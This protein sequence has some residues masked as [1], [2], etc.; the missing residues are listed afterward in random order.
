MLKQERA[1]QIM[2]AG[3]AEDMHWPDWR[4][5]I[6]VLWQIVDKTIMEADTDR[7]GKISFEEFTKM[8]E[9]TDVSLSMTLGTNLCLHHSSPCSTK[10]NHWRC[11]RSVLVESPESDSWNESN[12]SGL[13]Y[14]ARL[15]DQTSKAVRFG[16]ME[17]LLDLVEQMKIRMLELRRA[18]WHGPSHDQ[19][20]WYVRGY[21]GTRV[22]CAWLPSCSDDHFSSTR[23]LGY[24]HP[25]KLSFPPSLLP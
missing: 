19:K 4:L 1:F 13:V 15:A 7:D 23:K 20:T 8:V 11:R 12:L 5:T 2:G 14:C 17:A 16:W 3:T 6:R 21:E 24:L 25:S 18:A 9:N 10:L 22:P